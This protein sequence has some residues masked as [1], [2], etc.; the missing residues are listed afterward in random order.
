LSHYVHEVEYAAERITWL[1]IKE[2]VRTAPEQMRA[3]IAALQALRGI[4]QM[5]A[6]T[7]VSELGLPAQALDPRLS[8]QAPTGTGSGNE[9]HC[10]EGSMTPVH[11]LQEVPGP[12][13]EQTADRHRHRTRIARQSEV[14]PDGSRLCGFDPRILE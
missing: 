1:D 10:L 8:G 13:Q 6:V 4:A 9:R 12:R 11:A 5:T 2:G 3:V 14:A 7:I